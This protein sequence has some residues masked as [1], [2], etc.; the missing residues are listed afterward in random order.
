[1][2]VTSA[3]PPLSDAEQLVRVVRRTQPGDFASTFRAGLADAEL[4][5]LVTGRPRQASSHLAYRRAEL[6]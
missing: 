6:T 5:R 3:R 2:G 1:M 4:L